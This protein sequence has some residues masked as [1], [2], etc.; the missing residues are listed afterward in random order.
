[1]DVYCPKC[2]EPWDLDEFHDVADEFDTSFEAVRKD[3]QRRGCEALGCRPC[4][5]DNSLRSEA[6]VALYEIMGDDI[7][8]C[9]SMFEDFEFAGLL[10]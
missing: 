2:S 3:F 10:D 4:T 6:A 5:P 7:D 8:G 9:G 1:M